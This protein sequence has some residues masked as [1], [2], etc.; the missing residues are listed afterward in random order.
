MRC[1]DFNA[2]RFCRRGAWPHRAD[3]PIAEVPVTKEA[4]ERGESEAQQNGPQRSV[5]N[6]DPFRL[7]PRTRVRAPTR[8]VP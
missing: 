3:G 2:D 5:V 6:R 8:V 1:G 7:G 4:E